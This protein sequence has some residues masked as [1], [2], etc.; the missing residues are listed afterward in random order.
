MSYNRKA[1]KVD[2]GKYY[3]P[4]PYKKDIITDPAGQW[5]Y[6]GQITK[7][8][9]NTMATYG[10][11]YIP[12]YVIPDNDPPRMVYPNTGEHYFPNS[13]SFT[14][15]PIK[16]VGGIPELPLTAGR[17]A[18]HAWGYTNNDF[19]VNR[20]EGGASVEGYNEESPWLGETYQDLGATLS[21]GRFNVSAGNYFPKKVEQPSYFNPYVNVGVDLNKNRSLAFEATPGY[22]GVTFTKSF[23]DGGEECEDGR[24]EETDQIQALLDQGSMIPHRNLDLMWD[25][26]QS[27]DNNPMVTDIFGTHPREDARIEW[28]KRGA[29][30]LSK[31]LGLPSDS[32]ANN[33]MWAAG[34]G[35]QCLP[36]TKGKIPLTPFESNYKFINAVNKGTVPF[37]RV[38]VSHDPTFYKKE[39][40]TLQKGDIINFTGDN[41][42]HAMTFSHYREDGTPIFLDSNGNPNNFGAN[43]GLWSDMKPNKNRAAYISRFDPEKFY[44]KDINAL[45]EKARTNPTMINEN[46][47]TLPSQQVEGEYKKGGEKK[48]SKSIEATNRLFHENPITAKKKSKKKKIFDPTSKIFQTGGDVYEYEGRPEARYM[49][50]AN[51]RWLIKADGTGNKFVPIQDPDGSRSKVLN[52]QAYKVDPRILQRENQKKNDWNK[53]VNLKNELKVLQNDLKNSP[54]SKFNTQVAESTDTG[55]RNQSQE[56]YNQKLQRAKEIETYLKQRDQ[57]NAA[58]KLKLQKDELAKKDPLSLA[59]IEARQEW[60]KRSAGIARPVNQFWTLP[61][62]GSRAALQ[63]IPELITAGNAALDAPATIAGIEYSGLTAGNIL[64]GIGANQALMHSP[65][66]IHKLKTANTFDEQMNALGD[67]ASTVIAVSPLVKW[68]NSLYNT[69]GTPNSFANNLD[70][71]VKNKNIDP[72]SGASNALRTLRLL[73]GRQEG[74]AQETELTPEQIAWYR[75]QGYVV[76]EL[77]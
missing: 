58:W 31:R 2:L 55:R 45:E 17:K 42:S 62:A 39:K 60:E 3:K 51:G 35:Y 71:I 77:D 46:L 54:L 43:I 29:A 18:Y 63:A 57:K 13:N 38:D 10:Y 50:D 67:F 68:N 7:I 24:C 70:K 75:S 66:T 21:K 8:P 16:K 14:E 27:Q 32:Y 48:Y 37:S 61:I 52:A 34:S 69:L 11:G 41:T 22:A 5:K 15:I 40:G 1:L 56:A 33:C 65:E 73:S 49:K 74:G 26:V 9:G 53:I 23:Q 59:A 44:A 25:V 47:S 12:L 4:N 36:E 19:I 20:Q 28:K 72:V 30:D 64:R 76:E 6:P